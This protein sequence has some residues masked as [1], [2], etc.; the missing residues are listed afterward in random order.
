RCA[1]NLGVTYLYNATADRERDLYDP[2]R[3]RAAEWTLRH[4]RGLD[5][6]DA[7]VHRVLAW[8]YEIRRDYRR[9][10]ASHEALSRIEPAS[11][12]AW[13]N[14]AQM[15]ANLGRTEEVGRA[16]ARFYEQ[17]VVGLYRPDREL[18]DLGELLTQVIEAFDTVQDADGGQ[19]ARSLLSLRGRLAALQS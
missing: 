4:V 12:A 7:V 13:T 17:L 3:M 15:Q 16:A 5:E 11:A 14:I 6:S 18:A 19:R 8:V 10:L 2:R 1:H 9:A